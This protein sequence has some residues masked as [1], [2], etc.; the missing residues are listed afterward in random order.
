[1][2]YAER[3]DVTGY[4]RYGAAIPW[5]LGLASLLMTLWGAARRW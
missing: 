5:L 4:V 1:V 3:R 2:S